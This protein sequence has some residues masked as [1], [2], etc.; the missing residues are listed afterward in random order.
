MK[1]K[2]CRV[3]KLVK[4][5]DKFHKAVGNKDGY[6]NRC[7][8]CQKKYNDQYHAQQKQKHTKTPPAPLPKKCPK[9][10]CVK[11]FKD[12]YRSNCSKTGITSF[13]KTCAS[14]KGKEWEER[15]KERNKEKSRV[16]N[17][18]CKYGL[19]PQDY[20]SMLNKQKGV[21]CICKTNDPGKNRLYFTVDHCHITGAIRGLLCT[22]CNCALG[23]IKR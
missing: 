9:C 22:K 4:K 21:C 6:N 5:L 18:K 7:K 13:C 12:F 19:T 14:K 20:E 15:N 10:N 16:K 2:S 3:C 11:P 1:D 23:A 17:L 8:E